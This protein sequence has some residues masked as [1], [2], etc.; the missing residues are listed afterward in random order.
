MLIL[1]ELV[2]ISILTHRSRPP[3]PNS[4]CGAVGPYQRLLLHVAEGKHHG[5]SDRQQRQPGPDTPALQS[6]RRRDR[7]PAI[8]LRCPR[9]DDSLPGERQRATAEHTPAGRCGT[10]PAGAVRFFDPQSHI[11]R[12]RRLRSCHGAGTLPPRAL[13]SRAGI[14]RRMRCRLTPRPSVPWR[15]PRPSARTSS[16]LLASPGHEAV[17]QLFHFSLDLIAEVP[18]AVPFDKLLGQP[19]SVRLDLPSGQKRFFHGLCN[20]LDPGRQ[21]RLFHRLR[22]GRGAGVLAVVDSTSRAASFSRKRARHSQGSAQGSGRRF[23][24]SGHVPRTGLLRAVPRERL[25]L[26]SAG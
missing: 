1:T 17:S 26:R 8:R 15:C 19:I 6:A 10:R 5:G 23:R 4:R 16:C 11:F 24:V 7:F 22:D 25:R 2:R 18:T 12:E 9:H 13:A 3:F 21:R 14:V 20:R